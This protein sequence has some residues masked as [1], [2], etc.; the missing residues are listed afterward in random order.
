MEIKRTSC[1]SETKK[2]F[3]SNNRV[4]TY[5]VQII[6]YTKRKQMEIEYAIVIIIKWNLS[7]STNVK[8]N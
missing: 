3:T 1:S 6:L 4:L 7:Q 5:R 8:M 2:K